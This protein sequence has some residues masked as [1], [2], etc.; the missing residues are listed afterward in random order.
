MG[1]VPRWIIP[2]AWD[3]DMGTDTKPTQ[4]THTCPIA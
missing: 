2:Q 4:F 1:H 3:T